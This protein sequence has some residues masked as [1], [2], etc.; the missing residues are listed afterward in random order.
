MMWVSPARLAPWL[1]LGVALGAACPG[2]SATTTDPSGSDTDTG[3]CPIGSMGCPCTSGGTCDG[4]LVCASKVCISPDDTTTDTGMTTDPATTGSGTSH[5]TMVGEC[6]PADEKENGACPPAE[7]YCSSKGEC[8]ACTGLSSCAAADPSTPACDAGTGLC[9]ECTAEDATGCGGATP[10]CESATNTCR[11]CVEHAECTGSAC[12]I[13][14][15][16]CFPVADALWV[17]GAGDCDDGGPGSEAAPLCTISA[18]LARVSAQTPRAI[19]VRGGAYDDPL[20]VPANSQVAIVRAGPAAVTITGVDDESL[21]VDAGARVYLDG[22]ELAGNTAG[23][24]V[25]CKNAE[26]WVDRTLVRQQNTSGVAA[27]DCSLRLRAAVLTKNIGEG[28]FMAGGQARI[29]N[30]FITDN[31]DKNLAPTPRGGIALAGG[32]EVEI[33]YSTLYGNSAYIGAGYSIDCD[34]DPAAEK[35]TVRNSIVFNF[36][37]YSTFNCEG[38][39]EVTRS[40][41]SAASDAPDD[42]NV[43]VTTAENT[44][45]MAAEPAAPGV[46]RPKKGTKLDAV[47]LHEVGDPERD[48]EGDPRPTAES[49]FPGADQPQ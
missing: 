41:F 5:T 48:F 27:E 8:V 26:L 35:A 18:A 23:S 4:S 39:E 31:G 14:E 15:G 44:M 43:G 33:V 3:G 42:D 47:A 2:P 24:G 19:L 10:V 46:Y 11:A 45:L 30:S 49:S 34:P 13:A 21:R 32:A 29:E 28:L 9:V 17:D 6:T 40:A 37:G 25:G 38:A 22:L 1:G 20:A 16:A 36:T 7:P 12:D